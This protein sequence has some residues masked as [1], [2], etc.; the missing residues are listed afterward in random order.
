M[1]QIRIEDL[2]VSKDGCTNKIFWTHIINNEKDLDNKDH[3]CYLQIDKDVTFNRVNGNR[4]LSL[5]FN[6]MYDNNKDQ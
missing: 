4:P 6:L 3:T 2:R 5:L 1:I